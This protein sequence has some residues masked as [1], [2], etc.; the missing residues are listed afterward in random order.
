MPPSQDDDDN[1]AIKVE[2]KQDGLDVPANLELPSLSQVDKATLDSLPQDLQNEIKQEYK[3]RSASP[4]LSVSD[5]KSPSTSPEKKKRTTEKG[6]PLSRITQ[7]LGPKSRAAIS[8]G[9]HNIFERQRAVREAEGGSGSLS[10]VRVADEELR[11]LGIDR[12]VFEALP[13]ELQLEQLASAR[14]ARSFRAGKSS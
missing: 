8:A 7:A 12:E 13:R 9:K 2:P 5:G 10:G 4:A 1:A 11:K 6:T 3:R 14:F